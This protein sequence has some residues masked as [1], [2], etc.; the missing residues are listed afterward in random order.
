MIRKKLYFI[1]LILFS[2]CSLKPKH[3]PIEV[4]VKFNES[5]KYD[6]SKG[7]YTIFYLNQ[8]P[9][10][11]NF[12]LSAQEMKEIQNKYYSLNIDKI[13]KNDKRNEKIFMV[14]NCRIMPKDNTILNIQS[15]NIKQE[16]QIDLYCNSYPLSNW[17]EAR[18]VKRFIAFV[19]KI[20][21][22]KPEIKNAPL[23]D[24]LYM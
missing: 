17:I 18:H 9:T 23:S 1:L 24:I 6:L 4:I 15:K 7:E 11:I 16:I 14:D 8:P 13:K 3:E 12:H 19:V 2:S 10:I 22:S 21:R 20:I 5:Y